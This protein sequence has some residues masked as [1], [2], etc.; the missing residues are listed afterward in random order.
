MVAPEE[1]SGEGAGLFLA[2]GVAGVVA[3]VDMGYASVQKQLKLQC[4]SIR[5]DSSNAKMV[6][7]RKN[8]A[9]LGIA[10]EGQSVEDHIGWAYC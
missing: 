9:N 1:A 3:V 10:M 6:T 8:P 7:I 2:G 5:K 4:K